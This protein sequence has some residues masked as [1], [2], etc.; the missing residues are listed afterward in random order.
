MST[1]AWTS[2][3]SELQH[4]VEIG[5]K[6]RSWINFDTFGRL[7]TF[8][9]VRGRESN[10]QPVDHKSDALTITLP[11]YQTILIYSTVYF[12]S[13]VHT[14]VPLHTG[15][16]LCIL[17]N[18]QRK[19]PLDGNHW[20][21]KGDILLRNKICARF[22]TT[23][24]TTTMMYFVQSAIIQITYRTTV[25]HEDYHCMT[26]SSKWPPPKPRYF[27][28]ACCSTIRLGTIYTTVFRC[29]ASLWLQLNTAR[30]S[31]PY[32]RLRY[33]RR[34]HESVVAAKAYRKTFQLF[35]VI[36]RASLR[37]T[38]LTWPT[39]ELLAVNESHN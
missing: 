33:E 31:R 29:A 23:M 30:S 8:R 26:K 4:V 24:T 2:H 39:Y 32:W 6:S 25:E 10:S 16:F 15:L 19:L 17:G 1:Q 3:A 7:E 21:R 38:D 9:R 12:R 28:A 13:L 34:T 14:H 36:R 5:R 27:A 20:P 18:G 11:K 35:W 22:M 37:T